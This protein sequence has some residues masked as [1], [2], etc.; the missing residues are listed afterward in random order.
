MKVASS[1]RSGPHSLRADARGAT[2]VEFAFVAPVA[3]LLLIGSLDIGH[4]LYMRSVLHGAVNKAGRDSSLQDGAVA[5]NQT[6]IDTRVRNQVLSLA[7]SA[8]VEIKRRSYR[9]FT[10]AQAAR[11]EPYSDTDGNGRCN[12]EPYEDHNNNSVRDAD[13]GDASQGGAKD[14]VVYTVTVSYAR[15]FPLHGFIGGSDR[16]TAEAATVLT[17]QPYGKQ[18][19]NGTMTVRTCP[20]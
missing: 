13:G 20:L 1:S 14:T 6:V 11:P 7:R 2:L 8:N 17:N 12:G 16:V 9:S 5:A 15:L 18:G 3:C 10:E 4:S 19:T